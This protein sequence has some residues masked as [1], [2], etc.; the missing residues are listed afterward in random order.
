MA[1][2][3][4]HL[5]LCSNTRVKMVTSSNGGNLQNGMPAIVTGFQR[6]STSSMQA[7]CTRVHKQLQG[8]RS[9]PSKDTLLLHA[10]VVYGIEGALDSDTIWYV[11]VIKYVNPKTHRTGSTMLEMVCV[12]VYGK[13]DRQHV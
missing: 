7:M 2:F 8:R 6:L 13:Q 9:V 11:P 10:A 3:G 5:L 12:D 1:V 4:D